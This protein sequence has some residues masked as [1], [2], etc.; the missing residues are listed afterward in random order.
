MNVQA[1]KT[2]ERTNERTNDRRNEGMNELMKERT[3][4]SHGTLLFMLTASSVTWRPNYFK[5]GCEGDFLFAGYNFNLAYSWAISITQLRSISSSYEETL[6]TSALVTTVLSMEYTYAVITK[7]SEIHIVGMSSIRQSR[8]VFR[9][10]VIFTSIRRRCFLLCIALRTKL[11]H[12][13]EVTTTSMALCA[14]W[15][16][17]CSVLGLKVC[18]PFNSRVKPWV[19]KSRIDWIWFELLSLWMKP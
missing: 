15:L 4:D 5:N 12:S 8:H 2:N 9:T 19:N 11:F 7:K 3:K 18:N 10:R 13:V 6:D 14:L 16:N 17:V 1:N